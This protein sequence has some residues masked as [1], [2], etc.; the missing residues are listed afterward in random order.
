VHA[1]DAAAIRHERAGLGIDAGIF[2]RYEN[3]HETLL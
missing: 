1:R 3:T 2:Y